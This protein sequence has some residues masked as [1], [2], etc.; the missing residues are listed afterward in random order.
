MSY[1]TAIHGDN[2]V[3]QILDEPGMVEYSTGQGMVLV[4]DKQPFD[5]L[6]P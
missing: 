4:T 2:R 3:S 5:D 1:S 6:V